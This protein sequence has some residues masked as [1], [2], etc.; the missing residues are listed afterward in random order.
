MCRHHDTPSHGNSSSTACAFCAA[1]HTNSM[2]Q[3]GEKKKKVAND[4]LNRSLVDVFTFLEEVKA[5]P[6][7]WADERL[8]PLRDWHGYVSSHP[9]LFP[10]LGPRD[11][12]P[13]ALVL[14]STGKSTADSMEESNLTKGKVSRLWMRAKP[15]RHSKRGVP[16][17]D[18]LVK[19]LIANALKEA[20]NEKKRKRKERKAKTKEKKKNQEQT[21]T[22]QKN[23]NALKEA[24]KE[25]KR[26]RKES[27]AKKKEKKKTQEQTDTEQSQTKPSSQNFL[28]ILSVWCGI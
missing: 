3:Q 17:S 15:Q 23:V 4:K 6:S 12:K 18:V 27:K 24:D 21:D 2:T 13:T 25:K 5:K 14:A 1:C 22:E 26:K 28:D 19:E 7:M 8:E 9:D 16:S 10:P 20:D 11:D